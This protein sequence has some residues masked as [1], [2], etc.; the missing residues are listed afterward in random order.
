MSG[1][2]LCL[3]CNLRFNIMRLGSGFWNGRVTKIWYYI[4][5]GKH[6]YSCSIF[7]EIIIISYWLLLNSLM[8][9]WKGKN[10][11]HFLYCSQ[12]PKKIHKGFTFCLVSWK[13]RSPSRWVRVWNK[14]LLYD[15]IA[16]HQNFV[17]NLW[18]YFEFN[19][20]FNKNKIHKYLFNI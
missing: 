4:V 3:F 9:N 12:L 5:F 14:V 7:H 18:I 13:V 15:I 11:F 17:L 16:I 10:I 1:G 20:M 8:K 6:H 2:V 19:L